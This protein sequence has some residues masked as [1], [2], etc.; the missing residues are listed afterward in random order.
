MKITT[1]TIEVKLNKF[2]KVKS[3]LAI[4]PVMVYTYR[5]FT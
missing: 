5:F 2:G 4:K 3:T 1:R